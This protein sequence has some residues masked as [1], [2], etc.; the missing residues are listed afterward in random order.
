[1]AVDPAVSI[2][3]ARMRRLGRMLAADM[4]ALAP[5]AEWEDLVRRF[6]FD[7]VGKTFPALRTSPVSCYLRCAALQDVSR[8]AMRTAVQTCEGCH[9][10]LLSV[11]SKVVLVRGRLVHHGHNRLRLPVHPFH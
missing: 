7:R 10:S 4:A 8:L 1:M 6:E 5:N 11:S 2:A 9:K 3:G